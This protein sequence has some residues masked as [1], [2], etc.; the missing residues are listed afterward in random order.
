M[1]KLLL[2]IFILF[3]FFVKAQE[4]DEIWI[5]SQYNL[6]D[7]GVTKMY[8]DTLVNPVFV[9]NLINVTPT[10]AAGNNTEIQINSSGVLG[11]SPLFTY[12][13]ADSTLVVDSIQLAN[14]EKISWNTEKHTINIPTGFGST[15]QS[16]QEL[17]ILVY[18]N[19]G[20]FIANGTAVNPVGNFNGTH[21]I[22]L[23]QSNSFENIGVDYG[24]T[25]TDV[26]D[27]SFGFV[28]WFGEARDL[29][30]S[31][32]SLG[33]TIWISP[34]VAGELVNVMPEFPNYFIQL[35]IV[36]QVGTTDGIIF[37]TSRSNVDDTFKSFY[38]GTFRETFDF[39]VTATGGVITGTLSPA[40]GHVDMTMLFNDGFSLF[41]TS[42]SATV[43]LTAG[44]N[45]NPQMNYVYIPQSTKVLTVNTS[46]F[47]T[48]Q[49]VKVA[50][51]LLKS[52]SFVEQYKATINQN[53][54]D[55]LAD[56]TTLQGRLSVITNR[57]R[58]D[59]AKH[60]TG[61]EGVSTIVTAPT[62]DDVWASVTQGIV[63]QLNDHTF[64]AFDSQTG[65]SL[66]ISNHFTNPDT[67]VG[68]LNEQINDALGNT[69]NNRSFSFVM[70]GVVN[71]TGEPS[72]VKINLPTNS[73]AFASPDNAVSDALNYSVY[74]IP[75][76]Y[77]GVGFLIARFTYTY[78]NDDW[79][80]FDTE[81]LTG[82]TPNT[83]AGGGAG[84]AGVTTFL[85]LSDTESSYTAYEFQV[86]NAGATALESPA[87][88]TYN[89]SLK[90]SSGNLVVSDT[91]KIG[92]DL[93]V[94]GSTEI[95]IDIKTDIIDE[96]TTAVGVT[97]EEI[98][99][100]DD[101][102]FNST[103]DPPTSQNELANKQYVDDNILSS[104]GIMQVARAQVVFGNQTQTTIV[105]LPL[106]AVIWDVGVEVITLFDGSGAD[107]LDIGIT[108][109][110]NRYLVSY[111]ISSTQFVSGAIGLGVTNIP[112]RMSGSTNITFQYSD[113]GGGATQ[114]EAWVYIHYTVF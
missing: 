56:A 29:N 31:M 28:V 21:T 48:T 43:T 83:T 54:N 25:T 75:T 110:A 104:T 58:L 112:D 77:T 36:Q 93:F 99:L 51:L 85:G 90:L 9:R 82:F 26:D 13:P 63:A 70:W 102:V 57:I 74:S 33:D 10:N 106:D 101:R 53:I 89:D 32:F 86:A 50:K 96:L 24:L 46:G 97:I 49:H 109:T 41:D 1:K 42:P 84:G 92:Q 7:T 108:G 59:H 94:T 4:Y 76:E 11:S 111:D 27:N 37:V 88:L 22:G 80:L 62:P 91:A 72:L 113:V 40:N 73:Y 44:T 61:T 15:I 52:A 114:G 39:L 19:S 23:A 2:F 67:L 16:G 45:A 81:P 105:T 60:R 103:T 30:T 38:N 20:S 65:D 98:L 6:G 66:Y 107:L 55:G 95:G 12:N 47:P 69:L 14:G 17:Q 8:S 71:K 79:V 34:T 87:N 78:K 100:K 68:N 18:N 35:G 3:S 64:P 5:N